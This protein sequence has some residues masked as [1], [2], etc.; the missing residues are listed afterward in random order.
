[1]VLCFYR[2]HTAEFKKTQIPLYSRCKNPENR[3]RNSRKLKSRCIPA[4]KTPKPYSGNQEILN[5]AVFSQQK[6]RKQTAEFKKS[7]IPLYSHPQHPKQGIGIQQISKSRCQGTEK[8]RRSPAF[9][10]HH[11]EL[12]PCGDYVE[13]RPAET[14]WNYAPAGAPSASTGS[15]PLRACICSWAVTRP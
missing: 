14:M 13:L 4:A 12:R 9:R 8:G 7:Q 15:S 6:S 11:V 1:M 2:K 10:L 3:Q 5:P